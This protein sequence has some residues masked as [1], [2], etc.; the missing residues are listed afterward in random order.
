MA[1]RPNTIEAART[2]ANKRAEKERKALGRDKPPDAPIG[3][4]KSPT[5]NYS[6]RKR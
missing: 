2:R 6:K 4:V 1:K 3:M 5:K